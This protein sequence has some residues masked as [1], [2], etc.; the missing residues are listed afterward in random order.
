MKKILLFLCV[1]L[2]VF[3]MTGSASATIFVDTKSLNGVIAEDPLTQLAWG[4]SYNY[5]HATPTDFEIPWDVVNSATLEISGY[6][7]DDSNDDVE[8]SG[9]VIGSLTPGGSWN[10]YWDWGVQLNDSPSVSLFDIASVFSSWTTGS[11][12]DVTITANGDLLDGIIQ[13]NTSV[14]TLDY[15]NAVA[16]APVPEP[17][18]TILMGLGLLGLV[19]YGR[20]KLIKKS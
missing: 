14:F 11:P 4:D 1:V 3:G 7:I 17:S 16:T 20:K 10:Y 19:G 9:S 12:L 6:W 2:M 15:D 13:L 8:V 18:T 5:S